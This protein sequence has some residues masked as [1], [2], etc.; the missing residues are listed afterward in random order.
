MG[1]RQIPIIYIYYAR[2]KLPAKILLPGKINYGYF[3]YALFALIALSGVMLAFV[4]DPESARQSVGGMF[5]GRSGA[6][7]ARS[8]HY[9]ASQ[10]FLIFA[11]IHIVD[12]LLKRRDKQLRS[13][14]WLRLTL[15]IPVIFYAMLSGFILKGD[16]DALHA[17]SIFRSMITSLPFIGYDLAFMLLGAA[18]DL[19]LIYVHH[20]CTATIIIW[21]TTIEHTR[22]I[23]PPA[24]YSVYQLPALAFLSI[25]L[26]PGLHDGLS[27]LSKG[28]WYFLGVQEMMSWTGR[29]DWI[30]Y[31]FIIILGIFFSIKYL[32]H[33]SE[34]IA[35]RSI[36]YIIFAMLGLIVFGAWF[37][38]EGWR[39]DWPWNIRQFNTIGFYTIFDFSADEY[40]EISQIPMINGRQESCLGCHG[41]VSG[42]VDSH[43]PSALGCS[44]CHLGNP[45]TPDMDCSHEG[46]ILVPGNLADAKRTC[47]AAG[48]H[49]QIITRVENSIMNTVSGM[50]SVDKFAFGEIDS[51]G[52]LFHVNNLGNTAAGTHLKQMCVV[53]HIGQH[54]PMPDA[55]SQ[56][57]RGGG[58]NACHLNYSDS[59]K[60]FLI[61]FIT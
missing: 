37:R 7:L 40:P 41:N 1:I 59:A 14:V 18:D 54:K 21:L 30:S 42:F 19:L 58:C 25:L 56:Q 51:P 44:S 60:I 46:M 34:M 23:L 20:I 49:P 55:V 38:G 3:A 27:G 13:G 29:P 45:L 47:G 43:D 17:S 35:R 6:L 16:P 31:L 33:F 11:G 53:C 10:L 15:T 57:S 61:K 32:N 36:I 48:C 28:P 5:F 9:W 2:M 24:K 12:H 50:I 39:A 8:L 22:K 4:Y 26:I 52:G